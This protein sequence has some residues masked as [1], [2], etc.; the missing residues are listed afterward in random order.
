MAWNAPPTFTDGSVLTAAQQNI[1]RDCLNA[2]A[3]GVATSV[4]SLFVGRGA[5]SLAETQFSSS[6][7]NTAETTASGTYVE[8][9]TAQQLT[10]TTSTL[11]L[12]IVSARLHTSTVDGICFATF[13][14]NGASTIAAD[15]NLAVVQNSSTVNSRMRASAVTVLTGAMGLNAGSNTFKL[16]CK[17]TA[18]TLTIASRELLVLPL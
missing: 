13:V 14:V 4:G 10:L 18:G 17:V 11:A 3:A 12:V 6:R 2:T 16:V 5:N 7:V 8:P 9:T 1:L 15:D